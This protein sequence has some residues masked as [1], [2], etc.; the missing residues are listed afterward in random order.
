ML[1]NHLSFYLFLVASDGIVEIFAPDGQI[2]QSFVPFGQFM[3]KFGDLEFE[4]ID[5][6]EVGLYFF[7]LEV[8]LLSADADIFCYIFEFAA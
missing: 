5:L 1:V 7:V 4:L 3:F 2:M 8:V 6:G